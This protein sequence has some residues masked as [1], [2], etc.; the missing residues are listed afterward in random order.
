MRVTLSS[1]VMV[2]ATLMVLTV[3]AGM[4]EST[5]CKA[6]K[7]NNTMTAH[8]VATTIMPNPQARPMAALHQR[9][10]AVVSPRTPQ[11]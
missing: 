8:A 6:T 10:A 2:T 3:Q 1:P 9:L 4:S 7:A 5:R 11:P